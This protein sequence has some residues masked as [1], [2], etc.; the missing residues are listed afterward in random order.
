MPGLSRYYPPP[1][2][3]VALPDPPNSHPI[4]EGPLVQWREPQAPNQGVA[5][6]EPHIPSEALGSS[7]YLAEPDTLYTASP[8]A[9][10][11]EMLSWVPSEPAGSEGY[12]GANTGD[13]TGPNPYYSMGYA[14][15]PCAYQ[16]SNGP[17]SRGVPPRLPPSQAI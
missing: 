8:L 2:P 6:S 12:E 16:A 7:G 1:V 3:R 13:P 4:E 5:P 9:V 11:Q 14:P 17:G 15:N 10:H